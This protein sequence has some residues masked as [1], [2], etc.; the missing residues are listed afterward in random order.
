[1][2]GEK[3]KR[4]HLIIRKRSREKLNWR[5]RSLTNLK[6]EEP[7]EMNS[8]DSGE[9]HS[10]E[11]DVQSMQK[12]VSEIKE[13]KR[14]PLVKQK[15]EGVLGEYLPLLEKN[16][17]LLPSG[18][19]DM[20]KVGT[21][22]TLSNQ[23]KGLVKR[24]YKLISKKEKSESSME[25][26]KLFAAALNPENAKKNRYKDVLPTERTRVALKHS[27]PDLLPLSKNCNTLEENA[28]S[29]PSLFSAM[30]PR[31]IKATPLRK[32]TSNM[33]RRK[34]GMDKSVPRKM[35]E[36]PPPASKVEVEE[37]KNEYINA[38]HINLNCAGECFI[39][40]QAPLPETILDFWRMVI[41]QS[42]KYLQK[43]F[44]QREP[45]KNGARFGSRTSMQ[46]FA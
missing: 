8:E 24:E 11:I 21:P 38:N 34:S 9:Y 39:A 30:S 1:M 13:L 35:T 4:K 12:I 22:V 15:S 6:R 31:D 10:G 17:R 14:F 33:K 3:K 28:V 27:V 42:R 41:L 5:T 25:K 44:S 2:E 43:K 16:F 18:A 20:V 46:S 19:R 29:F 45:P 32:S 36:P 37:S 7:L 26:E 23:V 40:C